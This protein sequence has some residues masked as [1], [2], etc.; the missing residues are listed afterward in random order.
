M[1]C[2]TLLGSVNTLISVYITDSSIF[3]VEG[4][5]GLF[6]GA[7]SSSSYIISPAPFG[8]ALAPIGLFI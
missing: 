1:T 2:D 7:L 8:L 3:D 4:T 6:L 5:I